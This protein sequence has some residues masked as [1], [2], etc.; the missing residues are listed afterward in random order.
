[1][2]AITCLVALGTVAAKD[3][4]AAEIK[5]K[6]LEISESRRQTLGH[7]PRIHTERDLDFLL[8]H[9]GP[10]GLLFVGVFPRDYPDPAHNHNGRILFR[11]W[12]ELARDQSFLT[13]FGA[14]NK[15]WVFGHTL[16]RE[17]GRAYGCPRKGWKYACILIW[18]TSADGTHMKRAKPI[19]YQ[20]AVPTKDEMERAMQ[21][22][23]AQRVELP[24]RYRNH[25]EL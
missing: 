6:G 15:K 22:V 7:F 12:E 16:E 19:K 8:T 24:A 5:Q 14:P 23:A 25:D 1:M 18:K 17:L 4:T 21:K 10:N 2:L 9:L 3:Y 20:S 11:A 13:G